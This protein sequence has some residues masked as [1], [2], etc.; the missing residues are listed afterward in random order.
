M[1]RN[2]LLAYALA[3]QP[4]QSAGK[5]ANFA[6]LNRALS[7]V[8]LTLLGACGGG[9]GGN[10]PY[11]PPVVPLA[12]AVQLAET[13]VAPVSG[14]KQ[15]T[16]DDEKAWVRSFV[17]E[18]YLW[19]RDVPTLDATSYASAALYFDALKTLAKNSAGG[20]L[21]RFHW[22]ETKEQYD[23]YTNGIS[24][25]YGIDWSRIANS[26]PR[27][28]VVYNV[29]PQSAAGL[30]GV[31]RGD[32]LMKVDGIDFINGTDLTVIN[33]GVF[34]K[35]QAAHSF[36]FQ[37]G[38]ST[39]KLTLQAGQYATSPVR[40]AKV[41]SD[42]GTKVAYLYFDSFI[43]KS[44]DQLITAFANFK[45]Q[46]ATEL[47]IDMRYNGGGLLYISS[48]LAY[49][50]AG[51]GAS[52]GKTFDR[53]VY[54][55]KRSSENYTYNFIP[56]ALDAKYYYDYTRPLPSLN[57]KRVTL[58]VDHGTASASEAVIN[59]LMGI[60]VTVNLIGATTYGKPYGFTPQGNCGRYYYAVE[61]KGENHKGFSSF[62]A[63]FAPTC[64]VKDDLNFQLGDLAE[65]RLAEALQYLKTGRCTTTPTASIKAM[66]TPEQSSSVVDSKRARALM[67]PTQVH[68]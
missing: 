12:P 60:D 41:I 34:P 15:G 49:M 68:P 61:F 29:E 3:S 37:R 48:Q 6:R 4:R 14:Q 8:T 36:E 27:N 18:R 32:K 38:T 20:D 53:L 46:G 26:A 23:Q 28:Y 7:T 5:A 54:N 65:P 64:T 31:Q 22:S 42:N 62:D 33:N 58:L 16:V 67:I 35:D 57:L 17:D 10:S 11:I 1:N 66:G 52:S 13:C 45:Q 44:Q 19:Y 63:G 47:V 30:A 24:V 39:L 55:D 40:G 2:P 43:A 50:V 59:G 21:D 25:D 51:S 9:G 56:Y